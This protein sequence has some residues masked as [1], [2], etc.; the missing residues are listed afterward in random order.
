MSEPV[1]VV[2]PALNEGRV[3]G[4]VVRQV[5]ATLTEHGIL[6][7]VLV[8]DDGSTDDTAI[9]A[10]SAGARVLG[11]V[12]NLGY[13]Q[14]LKDGI[15]AA[16]NDLIVITD[17]DG[18]YP[19]DVLPS[20]LEHARRFDMVVGARQGTIYRGSP[21]KWLARKCFKVLGEFATGRTI[22][23]IN[24]GFRA[25]R[26]R[27]ILQYFPQISSGFSFTTTS[28]LAY[29]LDGR[30]VHYMPIDYH[31]RVG[32]SKVRYLR[33]T[34]RALQIVIETILTYNPIKVFL[35]LALPLVALG[36]LGLVAG[37]ALASGWIAGMGLAALCTSWL[38]LAIG[39][40][41]VT[42]RRVVVGELHT[43][44]L[45]RPLDGQSYRVLEGR[46]QKAFADASIEALLGHDADPDNH[47]ALLPETHHASRFAA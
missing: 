14:S 13:G 32:P 10:Q 37:A 22:D 2:L 30:L 44:R 40:A 25:F 18:T 24:S 21:T 35:M 7:E 45:E 9:A 6:H 36:G 15:L 46:M 23:D 16:A 41:A 39:C 5:C 17:A 31:R 29:L 19:I 26:R 1:T 43:L 20:L 11:H 42:L 8:V 3:I 27:D 34:L 33:D 4:D 12:Q 38:T 47:R 28:T